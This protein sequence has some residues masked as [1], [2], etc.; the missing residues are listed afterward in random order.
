MLEAADII[1]MESDIVKSL[2]VEVETHKLNFNGAFS[3]SLQLR[4]AMRT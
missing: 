1:F 2:Q 3:G 4:R